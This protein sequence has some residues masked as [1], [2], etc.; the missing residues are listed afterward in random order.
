MSST[1]E[2]IFDAAKVAEDIHAGH[3][4]GLGEYITLHRSGD[5]LVQQCRRCVVE[6][7]LPYTR[8]GITLDLE[9]LAQF[10]Y[11]HQHQEPAS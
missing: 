6:A 8:M 7:R 5:S 4:V 11:K 9:R 1:P 10:I 2:M 3:V